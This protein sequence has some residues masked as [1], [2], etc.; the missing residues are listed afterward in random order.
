MIAPIALALLLGQAAPGAPARCETARVAMPSSL[1]GWSLSAT[2]P[3]IGKA[4]TVQTADPA[5]IRGLR[6]GEVSR[7]GAAALVP[8]EVGDDATYRIALSSRA[9]VDVAAGNALIKASGH[10][11]GPPCTGIAKVVDFPL[12]RGRYAL[13]LTG[14]S[15]SSVKVLIARA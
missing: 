4:F 10:M 14:I 12:K 6:L 13:H 8:F 3:T 11:R 9:W 15:G 5:T 2:A 7:P 1:A